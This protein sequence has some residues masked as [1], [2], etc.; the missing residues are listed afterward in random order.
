M[1]VWAITG[2]IACGKSTV[3]QLFA[4]QGARVASADDDARAVLTDGSGTREAVL[5]AFGTVDRAELGKRIFADP[6][7]RKTL[8]AIVHPAIRRRMRATIDAARRESTQGLLLYEVPLLYEGGLET[9]FDGVIAV[10][11]S[12]EAQLGR[13]RARGLSEAAAHQRLAAQ[14]DP[15]EK[16]RRA[17]WVVSTDISLE[18][19]RAAVAT[20]YAQILAGESADPPIN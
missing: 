20:V 12:P 15:R 7:A 4:E 14:L 18:E 5:A 1:H 2:G 6:E 19:T 9:W 10:Q 13:L 3:S 8:N 16:V 17:Q 11:A